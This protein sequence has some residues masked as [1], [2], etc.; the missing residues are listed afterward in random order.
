MRLRSAFLLLAGIALDL[1]ACMT[2]R[3]PSREAMQAFERELALEC[4]TFENA[5]AETQSRDDDGVAVPRSK[6]EGFV[7]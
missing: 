3:K 7:D 4:R 1:I 5:R 2:E 6:C